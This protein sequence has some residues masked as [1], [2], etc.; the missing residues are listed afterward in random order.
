VENKY[1]VWVDYDY[2]EDH[3]LVYADAGEG[4]SKPVIAVANKI[5]S[6]PWMF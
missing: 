2:I 4:T 5:L 6:M 3:M 1:S